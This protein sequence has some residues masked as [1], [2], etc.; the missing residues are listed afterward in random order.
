MSG[1]L[2]PQ[3]EA[4]IQEALAAGT[5]A[6]REKLLEAAVESL[7][8]RRNIPMVPEE[9]EAAL[10]EAFEDEAAGRV[11]EFTEADWERY[12]QMARDAATQ[13]KRA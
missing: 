2:A 12:R 4:F 11:T 10:E 3:Y 5:F 9:H 13:P 7:R 8:E 1:E 6:S